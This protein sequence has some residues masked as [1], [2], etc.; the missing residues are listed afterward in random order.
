MRVRLSQ[1]GLPVPD[2]A[3]LTGDLDA[4]RAL[5]VD[6]GERHRWAVVL[7]AIRG[8]YDGRG[9]WILGDRDEALA[10]FDEQVGAGAELIVEQKVAMRRELSAMIARSPF[11]Q[12]GAWPVETIQRK[13]QCAVVLAPAARSRSRR[14]HRGPADGPGAGR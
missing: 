10:V 11:G 9:V 13:G 4:A 14:R 5:P 12:G 7:K 6:F 8:G 3:D 1:L 2:F